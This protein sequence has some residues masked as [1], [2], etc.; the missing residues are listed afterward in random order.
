[1]NLDTL[2]PQLISELYAKDKKNASNDLIIEVLINDILLNL[3]TIQDRELLNKYIH[4]FELIIEKFKILGMAFLV[5]KLHQNTKKFNTTNIIEDEYLIGFNIDKS[6][7]YLEEFKRVIENIPNEFGL[8]KTLELPLEKDDYFYKEF[9]SFNIEMLQKSSNTLQNSN[10]N[11]QYQFKLLNIIKKISEHINQKIYFYLTFYTFIDFLNQTHQFQ[12]CR[13]L[14][15]ELLIISFQDN[16][17]E[18]AYFGMFKAYSSQGDLNIIVSLIWANLY[19]LK[20]TK[21]DSIS[22]TIQKRFLFSIQ[23]FFRNIHFYDIEDFYFNLIKKI[24]LDEY[25]LHDLFHTHFNALLTN[26]D[27]SVITELYSFLNKHRE[28]ILSNHADLTSIRW[29]SLIYNV[30]EV[31]KDIDT[32]E[33]NSYV[34]LFEGICSKDD[35]EKVKA[36]TIGKGDLKKIFIEY[37]VNLNRT[38]YKEDIVH[39][40]HTAAILADKLIL[41]SL[42]DS[43]PEGVILASIIK[44]DISFDFNEA[45][46]NYPEGKK[47]FNEYD[48]KILMEIR[49]KYLNYLDYFKKNVL[50]LPTEQ[51]I[52]LLEVKD[53]VFQLT[54]D[55]KTN[56][57]SMLKLNN[58]TLDK[59]NKW[60]EIKSD[61]TNFC[62]LDFT[63]ANETNYE[64]V[65]K[66]L[67][68]FNIVTDKKNI[69]LIKDVTIS[70]FPNNL[71]MNSNLD[72]ITENNYISQIFT[73]DWFINETKKK[74]DIHNLIPKMWIPTKTNDWTLLNLQSK[75]ETL[76]TNFTIDVYTDIY[77]EKA[78]DND[79]NIFIAHGANDI[80][81]NEFLY[82]NNQPIANLD[83][84]I[85]QGKLA[86]LFICHSGSMNKEI[87]A[88]STISLIKHFL[89][90]NYSSIIAPFWALHIDIVPL[91][92]ENFLNELN[93]G[94]YVSD[95]FQKA[96]H[97]IYEKYKRPGLGSCLHLYGNPHLKYVS[98]T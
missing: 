32:T 15:E 9:M 23:K 68:N 75:L 57:S 25:E 19:C 29:L 71:I 16:K 66:E 37:L 55:L 36:I 24:R 96:N 22:F 93:T 54:Y 94:A 60:L 7:E 59:M 5:K 45:D 6:N 77:P 46:E 72:F 27:K 92:L 56:F 65:K 67:S 43:E 52:W 95:A 74:N 28:S 83:M 69:L 48:E 87:L 30:K 1:M 86:L 91:W 85:G 84:L 58:W 26:E 14:C 42:A 51:I 21:M 76:T 31:F 41:K 90:K 10:E 88:Y 61:L 11:I 13:D 70:R 12:T 38:R 64:N 97:I 39:E 80:S 81:S 62:D 34:Q 89:T 63:E 20:I 78:L 82:T 17:T 47:L 18:L 53:N 98:Q 79:I 33:L 2:L 3:L 8:T 49:N 50:L 4:K 40:V 44:A 73:V 35:V